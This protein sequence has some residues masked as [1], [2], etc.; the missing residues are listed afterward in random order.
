MLIRRD[1][2]MYA[3]LGTRNSQTGY[4]AGQL[5]LTGRCMQRCPMCHSWREHNN[6]PCPEA[7]VNM[8]ETLWHE[9]N[10]MPF[11]EH[12]TL[13]GGDPQCYPGLEVLARLP[14]DFRLQIT[15]AMMKPPE[16]WYG[17]FDAIRLSL[18]AIDPEIYEEIRG[19]RRDPLEPLLWCNALNLPFSTFTVVSN[20]NA[21]HLPNILR[22][23]AVYRPRKATFFL[24]IGEPHDE[25]LIAAYQAATAYAQRYCSS[26]TTSFSEN[27]IEIEAILN[28]PERFE[29][30]RSKQVPLL[31]ATLGAV[32]CAASV[33]GF[34]MKADGT[35][36]PC[37]VLGGEAVATQ[38]DA[39]LGVFGSETLWQIWNKNLQR[40]RFYYRDRERCRTQC[41]YKQAQ[42]NLLSA[43]AE[44][45][46]ISIP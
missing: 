1:L 3:K 11:F 10:S 26:L 16:R 12:L 40:D 14:R 41:Q 24:I 2:A 32:E 33:L 29:H 36:F 42:I 37:C 7:D 38:L 4:V 34:H 39:A 28:Q 35:V 45:T 25:A 31:P 43:E 9:L 46:R 22:A 13:T 17:N 8:L 15:T 23:L 27:P 19:V 6:A 5:E 21:Q 44:R 30:I 18:D 20:H